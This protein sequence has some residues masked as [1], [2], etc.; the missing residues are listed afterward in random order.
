MNKMCNANNHPIGCNC[1]W[2]GDGH[3]GK[4]TEG[5][6]Y[7][8]GIK[9][10]DAQRIESYLNPNAKCPVCGASVYFYKSQNG[11]RVF[12]DEL[13][14]PWPKH[15][16]TDNSRYNYPNLYPINKH[17]IKQIKWQKNGWV[18][19]IVEN[20]KIKSV[21]EFIITRIDSHLITKIAIM[22]YGTNSEELIKEDLIIFAKRN[23]KST[24]ILSV[25]DV[26]ANKT[27]DI[28]LNFLEFNLDKFFE[29][30][31]HEISWGF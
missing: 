5:N 14:P 1:G 13:G 7:F 19:V 12:F 10:F 29:K 25:F 28:V 21:Y 27:F 24:F 2:G 17:F 26:V 15:P 6:G 23:D 22:I 3:L 4:R 9:L 30:N 20:N 31:H 16:C 11:G 8:N 18:P